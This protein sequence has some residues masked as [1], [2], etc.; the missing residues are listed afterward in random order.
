MGTESAYHPYVVDLRVSN[1]YRKRTPAG[2]NIGMD[3]DRVKEGREQGDGW[4]RWDQPSNDRG[5]GEVEMVSAKR[6]ESVH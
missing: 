4:D 2:C 6:K 5:E 3:K 1:R